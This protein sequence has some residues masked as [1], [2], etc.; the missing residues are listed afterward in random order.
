[1]KL[2]A[3]QRVTLKAGLDEAVAS[4]YRKQAEADLLKSIVEN[5][6]ETLQMEPKLFK[7]LASIAY[8]SNA[9]LL[10]DET[11]ELLDLAEELGLYTNE[12]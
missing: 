5:M 2:T 8:K 11:T 6:K 4:L 1:M 10:N 3:E 7:K 9:K 12:E